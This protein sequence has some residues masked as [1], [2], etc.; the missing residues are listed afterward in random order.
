MICVEVTVNGQRRTIA[1][2]DA[3]ETIEAAV[4]TYPATQQSWLRVTGDIV[5][6]KQPTA[7]AEWLAM[8]LSVGDKVEVQLIETD[9]PVAPNLSRTDPTLPASDEIPFVCAFCGKDA[10]HTEGMVASRKA[11]ICHD[12]ICYL[13]EMINEGDSTTTA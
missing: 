10:E 4:L 12:C 9:D 8:Q 13:H 1:G 6:G 2:A 11:M 7:D 3:A 5:P